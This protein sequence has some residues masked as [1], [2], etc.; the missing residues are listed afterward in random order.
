[1]KVSAADSQVTW[2]AVRQHSSGCARLCCFV[3]QIGALTQPMHR[4]WQ[5][6]RRRPLPSILT[7]LETHLPP[8]R[9][10]AHLAYYSAVA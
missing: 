4:T 5:S 6:C 10:R 1:M 9:M 8:G 2:R 7:V 3:K